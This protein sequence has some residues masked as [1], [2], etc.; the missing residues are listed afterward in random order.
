MTL[1]KSA[2][3]ELSGNVASGPDQMI[4]DDSE[5]ELHSMPLGVTSWQCRE[6]T[7]DSGLHQH[8]HVLESRTGSSCRS[9]LSQLIPFHIDNRQVRISHTRRR[10]SNVFSFMSQ[11]GVPVYRGCASRLLTILL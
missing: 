4:G 7:W 3:A 10:P 2:R 11:H 9:N 6:E 1:M 5:S 8:Q